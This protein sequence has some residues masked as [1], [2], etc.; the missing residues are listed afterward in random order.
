MILRVEPPCGRTIRVDSGE[1]AFQL[2]TPSQ[3]FVGRLGEFAL[4]L[5]GLYKE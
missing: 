2:L 1:L 5:P 4:H 3:I